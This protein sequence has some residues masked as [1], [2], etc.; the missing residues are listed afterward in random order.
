[1]LSGDGPQEAV[2]KSD[3]LNAVYCPI[4]WEDQVRTFY[5][6]VTTQL[7]EAKS[8]RLRGNLFQL[9]AVREYVWHDKVLLEIQRLT[10][11]V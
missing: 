8:E 2:Q 9:D 1:M 3:V 5:E 4:H 7:V 6:D 10:W 11:P